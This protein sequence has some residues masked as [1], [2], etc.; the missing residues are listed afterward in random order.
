MVLIGVGPS[1]FLLILLRDADV[2]FSPSRSSS[3]IMFQ[4]KLVALPKAL[5]APLTQLTT[6]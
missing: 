3:R 4:N 5:F 1:R 2:V 6:L